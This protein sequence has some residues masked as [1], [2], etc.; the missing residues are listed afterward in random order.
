MMPVIISVAADNQLILPRDKKK[1]HSHS[2]GPPDIDPDEL[3]SHIE[4]AGTSAE[5]VSPWPVTLGK[6]PD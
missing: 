2:L 3:Y 5:E 1:A 4:T 6:K